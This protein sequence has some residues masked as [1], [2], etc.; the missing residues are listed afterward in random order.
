MSQHKPAKITLPITIAVIIS[1]AF[2]SIALHEW[3]S[4]EKRNLSSANNAALTISSKT[5]G[6]SEN[7][8]HILREEDWRRLAKN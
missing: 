8:R 2:L 6:H 5:S 4:S 7:Q 3:L 1:I